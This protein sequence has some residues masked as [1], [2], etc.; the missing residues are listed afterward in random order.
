M[1]ISST[2]YDLKQ[3]R[4]DIRLFL[5]SL[6]INPILSEFD[7]FPVDPDI[8]A[9]ENCLKVVDERS[10]LFLLVVGGRYGLSHEEGKSVTNMEYLRARAKGIPVYVFVQKS[11]LSILPLWK[12]NPEIDFK[13]VADSPKLFEFVESLKSSSGVWIF[14][15]EVAQD[16]T[17]TLRKQL[18]Y[19]FL[20]ALQLRQRVK[21]TGLPESLTQLQGTPLRIAIERPKA[22]EYRLFVH[23]LAQEIS[24]VKRHRFDLQHG[25]A[26][27]KGEHLEGITEVLGWI[28]RRTAEARRLAGLATKIVNVALPDAL[29]PDGVP[30]DAEKIVFVAQGLAETYRQSIEWGI[31]AHR[32]SLGDDEFNEIVRIVGTFQNN[33]ISEI[34]EFSERMVRETE[35]AI[36][37][38]PAP[39]EPPRVLKFTLKI[40]MTGEPAFAKELKRLRALFGFLDE[41]DF[42]EEVDEDE[43]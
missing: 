33:M 43:E 3:V 18:A 14:P 19:L 27:G 41:T 13:A 2:C 24:R 1:F 31:E 22:W 8:T 5:E 42:Y 29:G 23:A 15:F 26:F 11:I 12:D 37:N 20:D 32:V 9:V 25:L 7:S 28:R 36:N 4:N 39:G 38:L 6:G 40:T 21:S 17:E 34:E 10:D 30:G 35:E 16:I